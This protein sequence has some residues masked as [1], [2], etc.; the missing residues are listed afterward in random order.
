MP[1]PDSNLSPFLGDRQMSIQ[2][3]S[4]V[5]FSIVVC[6]LLGFPVAG[7][8]A[9][10]RFE[11]LSGSI[12][13]AQ[14]SLEPV[15]QPAVIT[16]TV[17]KGAWVNYGPFIPPAGGSLTATLSGS[18]DADLYVRKN[19]PPNYSTF[20]C[21]PHTATSNEV[22]TVAGPGNVYVSVNG[23]GSSNTFALQISFQSHL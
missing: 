8:I 6:G 10:A 20:D 11:P 2:M 18:G 9:D 5:S 14:R 3:K 1:L 22:C 7:V 17:V 13:L 15:R 23:Y 16:G 19:S 12:L 21:R 4:L